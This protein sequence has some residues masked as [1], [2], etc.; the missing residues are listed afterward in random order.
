[1]R[2]LFAALIVLAA[3]AVPQTQRPTIKVLTEMVRVDVLVEQNG[4]PVSGLTAADFV[5]EDNGIPQRVSLL[6]ET[7]DVTV[8]SILDVSGSMTTQKLNNAGAGIRALMAALHSRDRHTL[9][10][11]AGDVRQLVL[12]PGADSVT[13]DAIARVRR[14]ITT[15]HTSLFDALF[16]AI[17]QNDVAPGPKMVAVLTDGLNNTSWLRTTRKC[18]MCL[19]CRRS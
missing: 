14:E 1:M 16:A 11:F 6:R 10:A 9:Y 17:V 3:G 19:V 13:G 8:S 7:E 18:N 4:S 2:V 5:V 12:P 15:A